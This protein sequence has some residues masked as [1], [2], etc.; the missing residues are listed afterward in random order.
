MNETKQMR[1]VPRSI[2]VYAC[3]ITGLTLSNLFFAGALYW[4]QLNI[5]KLQQEVRTAYHET[6]AQLQDF[7]RPE[8]KQ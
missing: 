8:G 3:L 4:Q 5:E 2:V 6:T 7:M 1:M